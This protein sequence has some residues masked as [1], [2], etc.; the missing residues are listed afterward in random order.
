VTKA[1]PDSP[2]PPPALTPTPAK[3]VNV[4]V[5][6]STGSIGE[7]TLDVLAHLGP[8]WRAY[9]LAAC[10]SVDRLAEQARRLA[11][12]CVVIARPELRSELASRLN[13]QVNGRTK[14]T[15]GATAL[16]ELASDPAVDAV[17]SGVVGAAG[18]EPTLAAVMAGKR[19]AIA[20]KEPLVMA[21]RRFTEAAR[22]SGASILPVDSEHSA[23]FQCLQSGRAEEVRR[24]ILTASG[25]P[26]RETPP[27]ALAEVTVEQALRHPNWRMGP[28]ITVDSATMM[29]KALEVVE[30]RWLFDMPPE[31]IEVVIHPESVVHSMVEFADGSLIAQMGPPDMR[32]PI[33]YALTW[34]RRL[35]G[36]VPALDLATVGRLRF[37]APDPRRYPALALG[38]EV[39][40]VGGTSGAVLNAANEAA[41]AAFL[42]RRLR[43]TE[44]TATVRRVLEGHAVRP[45]PD[46]ADCLEADRWARAEAERIMSRG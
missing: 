8:G 11:P 40:R 19:V 44:I 6:G 18:L 32:T 42:D 31:R 15:A 21:G 43:F 28:K 29:N 30:A 16:A 35:P 12:E 25:G 39:A 22:A 20:N 38:F 26:F 13:G 3:P 14:V 34:P 37:E 46:L 9:G 23:I 1:Q 7:N 10:K 5:L 17:V 27:A 4:V 24:I 36:N 33:Q 41:V 2:S 45:D